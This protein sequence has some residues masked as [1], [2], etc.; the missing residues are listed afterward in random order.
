MSVADNPRLVTEQVVRVAV[1]AP[2]EVEIVCEHTALPEERHRLVEAGDDLWVARLGGLLADARYGCRVTVEGADTTL[3]QSLELVTAPLPEGLPTLTMTQDP[4][5]LPQGYT[6]FN[7]FREVPPLED[8]AAVLVD[9]EGRIRWYWFLEDGSGAGVDV[10]LTASGNVLIGGGNHLAP[11]LVSPSAE[12]VWQGDGTP[13]VGDTY[14]HH[15]AELDS[16]ELVLLTEDTNEAHGDTWRGFGVEILDPETG[17]RS[18][19]WTSQ[20]AIDRGQL[21]APPDDV[22]DPFHANSV[23]VVDDDQGA[24]VW[25]SLAHRNQ[26]VRID[27]AS[28]DLTHTLGIGGDFVLLDALGQPVAQASAWFYGQHDPE[29]DLPHVLLYDN[30]Y[31]RPGGGF[32]R[33]LELELDWDAREARV[34]TDWREDGWYEPILGD[35]DRLENGHVLVSR[36]RCWDYCGLA[37]L[38]DRRSNIVEFAPPG[39]VV[40]KLE[41]GEDQG[42]YRAERVD[43]CALFNNIAYCAERGG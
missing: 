41:F 32:S 1:S 36:G 11:T 21:A 18:W 33:V 9:P 3:E 30:G 6:L 24:A 2:G 12:V 7:A 5:Y 20:T 26:V 35:A 10:A 43:G 16:G 28:G 25:V 8:I 29:F 14:H 15:A 13:A 37:G 17:A 42:I 38:G 19:T 23:T 31:Q 34:A 22:E 39:D 40:W 27:R 4:E